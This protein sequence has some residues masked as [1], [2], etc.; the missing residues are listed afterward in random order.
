MPD[1]P[2]PQGATE[3]ALFAECWDAVL[4]YADLCTADSLTTH[5]LAGEAFA[6]GMRTVRGAEAASARGPGRLPVI[7]ELLG[8]VRATAA[9]WEAGGRGHALDPGLRQWLRS[10]EGARHTGPPPGRPVALR[11]LRDLREPD[12]SLLWLAEV[13]ALP[14]PAVARRL[15]LDA[16]GAPAELDRARGVFRDRCRRAHL[17]GSTDPA[18]RGYARLLDA[19]TRSPAAEV[20][21]DL[22]DHLADCL[23][24]A[25]AAACLRP[26]GHGLPGALAGGVVGWGGLAYLE[27]RRRAAESRFGHAPDTGAPVTGPATGTRHRLP[28]G[29][30]LAGA[31]VVLSALALGASM[32]PFGGQAAEHTEAT[33]TTADPFPLTAPTV[34]HTARPHPATT[35]PA[36]P[37]PASRTPRSPHSQ[38][39]AHHRTPA[40]TPPRATASRTDRGRTAPRPATCHVVYHLDSQWETG[41]QATVSLTTTHPVNAWRLTWTFPDAQHTTQMWDATPD[42]SGP[43]ITVTSPSYAPD[44]TPGTPAAFGFTGTWQG[45]NRSPSDFVL[46]GAG[47]GVEI[48]N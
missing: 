30:L 27:R 28:R 16:A 26:Y 29:S 17:D 13:E 40:S 15:G 6:A 31:V 2:A 14:L 7:V 3:A 21:L 20:P 4:S 22:S 39:P 25:E 38:P 46:N 36:A 33:T 23:R 35:R 37:A 42:Q 9:L 45:A 1:L 10:A 11:G 43:R 48:T 32:M 12:A 18:C 8:A 19:V 24:C 44:L 41:F 5:R 47:C 34:S